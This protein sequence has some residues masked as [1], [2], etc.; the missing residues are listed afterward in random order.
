MKQKRDIF[1]SKETMNKFNNTEFGKKYSKNLYASVTA[2][3]ICA[4]TMTS[5]LFVLKLCC[6][7]EEYIHFIRSYGIMYIEIMT[8]LSIIM[9]FFFGR[10]EGA[11]KQ[12][13]LSLNK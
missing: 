12:F 5:G 4:V 6:S 7:E 10:R 2:F 8:L 3:L 13:Q 9:C 1:I 11:I